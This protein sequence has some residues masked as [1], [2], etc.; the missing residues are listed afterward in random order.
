MPEVD[1]RIA[2]YILDSQFSA[3]SSTEILLHLRDTQLS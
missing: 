3:F 2:P 1:C